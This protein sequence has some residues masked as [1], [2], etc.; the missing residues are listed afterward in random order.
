MTIYVKVPEP[1]EVKRKILES[2]RNIYLQLHTVL[3]EIHNKEKKIK[4]MNDAIE[5]IGEINGLL[6]RLKEVLPPGD[7]VEKIKKKKA[8]KEETTPKK[9]GRKK[10]SQEPQQEKVEVIK[11]DTGESS[12]KEEE[13]E[14][15]KFEIDE[16]K[17]IEDEL[18][19]IEEELKNLV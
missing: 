15:I 14:T 11:E 9:R 3:E 8:K 2:K 19:K 4:L 17:Q 10:K 13:K 6:N 12:A 1:I 18:K 16:L 5:K 7:E